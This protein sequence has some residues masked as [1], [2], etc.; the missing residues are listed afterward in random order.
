MSGKLTDNELAAIRSLK[1]LEKS[2]PGSLWL[3]A[4]SGTLSVMRTDLDGNRV[5]TAG[6]GFD[7]SYC[8]ATVILPSDGGDW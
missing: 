4:A 5:V 2:W 6:G 3:F 1:Q 7:E 8:V